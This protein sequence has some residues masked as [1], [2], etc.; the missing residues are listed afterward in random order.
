MSIPQKEESSSLIGGNFGGERVGAK[1][2]RL[3]DMVLFRGH[4]GR[5]NAVLYL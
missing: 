3:K 4:H 2:V 5:L 1:K